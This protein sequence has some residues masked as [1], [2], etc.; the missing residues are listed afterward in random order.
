VLAD[1]VYFKGAWT[2][3]FNPGGTGPV[4]FT[5][6]NGTVVDVPMMRGTN[7]EIGAGVGDGVQV[8]E[9]PYKDGAFAMD[10]LVAN[11]GP[12]LSNLETSL[13]ADSLQATLS[14]LSFQKYDTV[15]MPK[16][17]FNDD[18]E[19]APILAAMGMPDLFDP[20]KADLSGVDGMRDLFV[21][22]VEHAALIEVDEQGTIAA[23]GT[24]VVSG[25]GATLDAMIDQPFL[26][27][28]RNR[29]TGDILFIGR[30]EDPRQGS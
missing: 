16:F 30:V 1:T 10:L 8:Y 18:F 28:I 2:T 11:P 6:S 27:L 23:A 19:L 25:P 22:K 24:A 3:P 15:E 26:F 17:S 7:I 9:L 14:G 4:P 5:L 12:S 13:G 29:K 21:K 20:T